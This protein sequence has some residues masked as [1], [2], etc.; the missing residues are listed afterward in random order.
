MFKIARSYDGEE[1]FPPQD[2]IAGSGDISQA[3]HSGYSGVIAVL[4]LFAVSPQR[5]T[6]LLQENFSSTRTNAKSF[7][8]F[9]G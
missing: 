6:A 2:E 8:L 1:L 3:K 9:I 7:W 5:L 4:V